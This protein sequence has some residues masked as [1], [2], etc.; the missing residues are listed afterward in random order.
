MCHLVKIN[1]L[2]FEVKMRG[3]YICHQVVLHERSLNEKH[4]LDVQ[5]NIVLLIRL[6]DF[7][8]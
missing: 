8:K 7:S 6:L 4:L 5:Q 3:V 1:F 2:D